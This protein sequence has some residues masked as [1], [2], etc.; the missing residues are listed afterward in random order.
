MSRWSYNTS[1]SDIQNTIINLIANHM[2]DH[3]MM[4]SVVNMDYEEYQIICSKLQ[5]ISRVE[6][7]EKYCITIIAT[8]VASN[9]FGR[10]PLF[11]EKVKHTLKQFP[12]HYFSFIIDSFTSTFYNYQIDTMG[13]DFKDGKCIRK[14]ILAHSHEYF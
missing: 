4:S 10:E 6:E 1:L 11:F 2:G 12:Q 9:S 8:W 14:V 7:C 3:V 13:M 5:N